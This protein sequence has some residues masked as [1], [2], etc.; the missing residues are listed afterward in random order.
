MLLRN[1]DVALVTTQRTKGFHVKARAA[2][3]LSSNILVSDDDNK[4]KL[5]AE[6]Y[7]VRTRKQKVTIKESYNIENELRKAYSKTYLLIAYGSDWL[8][9]GVAPLDLKGPRPVTAAGKVVPEL[10]VSNDVDR[11]EM[12]VC[13]T[14]PVDQT[15]GRKN[16]GS[17]MGC[18]ALNYAGQVYGEEWAKDRDWEWLHIV[19]HS[20]GGLDVA[21]N[22]VAGTYNANTEM[23]PYESIIRDLTQKNAPVVATYIVD[24]YPGTRVALGITMR[25]SWTT[26]PGFSFAASHHITAQRDYVFDKLQYDLQ[27]IRG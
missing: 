11:I 13:F 24:V 16:L 14:K 22:L 4:L 20:L 17:V 2:N 21:D 19:A 26:F 18:S 8:Y 1:R 23:I 5:A 7:E 15:L 6:K 25:W 9:F 27:L 3:P 10:V 12:S